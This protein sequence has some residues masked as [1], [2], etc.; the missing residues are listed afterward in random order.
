MVQ[1][2]VLVLFIFIHHYQHPLSFAGLNWC[3]LT[4]EAPLV[5]YE[6]IQEV[7]ASLD[8]AKEISVDAEAVVDLSV[9][10]FQI[11]RTTEYFSWFSF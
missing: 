5:D 9:L 7:T 2:M 4:L 10:Y 3:K 6:E 1:V 11:K 8:D